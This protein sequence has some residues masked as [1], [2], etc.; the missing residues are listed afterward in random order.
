MP[1]DRER[2]EIATERPPAKGDGSGAL[3][4]TRAL[5]IVHG[6]DPRSLGVA[7]TVKSDAEVTVGRSDASVV[8]DDPWLS[9]CHLIL[10]NVGGSVVVRDAHTS[11]GSK[12]NG[13]PSAERVLQ[14]GDVVRIGATLL[15]YGDGVVEQD[16]LGLAGRSRALAEVRRSVR[17]LARTS[18]PVHVTGPTGCGKEVVA[19][20]IHRESRRPGTLHAFNVANLVPGLVEAQLFG[21]G[22][23]VFTG[24]SVDREGLFEAAN[25]QTL[26]LDEIGELAL[27][28]QPKLL[29]VAETG[30][31]HRL[32]D[33]TPRQVDVRL[34]TATLRS[35]S[36]LVAE[37]RFREDLYWR[38]CHDE[39]AVPG[40]RGRPLDIV[41]II[42]SVLAERGGPTLSALAATRAAAYGMADIVERLLCYGWPGNARELRDEVLRIADA[43]AQVPGQAL[44]AESVLGRRLLE[45]GFAEPEVAE[46]AAEFDLTVLKDPEALLALIRDTHGGNVKGFAEQVAR[47]TG[48][49]WRTIHRGVY[50]TLGK[51]RLARL[52]S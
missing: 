20:A 17:A 33:A 47:A 6:I 3:R 25:G 37:G 40:L 43:A 8:I 44:V 4:S 10:E 51:E 5:W 52:R 46:D 41:P 42:A 23:G 16:D 35:L 15:V 30:S 39:I 21:H 31:V 34:I 50:D 2:A 7:I 48:K 32:G 14:D 11:N 24:A 13:R 49:P 1:I 27:E 28:L 12:V 19:R 38:L 45:A 29:R 26:L 18:R 9:R 36:Q 22:R